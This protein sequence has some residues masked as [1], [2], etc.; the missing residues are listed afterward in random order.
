MIGPRF[1]VTELEGFASE[2]RPWSRTQPGLSVHVIDVPY[3][4]RIVATYRSEDEPHRTEAERREA[5]RRRARGHALMLNG[6]P[7]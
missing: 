2:A 1:I 6:G 7:S 4:R 5:I 3:A